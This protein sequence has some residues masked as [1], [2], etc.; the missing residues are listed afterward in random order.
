VTAFGLS[1]ASASR[2]IE[3]RQSTSVPNTSKN[4]A[5]TAAAMNYS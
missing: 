2:A 5:F 4:R 1:D 3:L